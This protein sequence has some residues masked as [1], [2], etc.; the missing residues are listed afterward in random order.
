MFSFILKKITLLFLLFSFSSFASSIIENKGQVRQ[1]KL[2]SE[3]ILFYTSIN[4]GTAYFLKDRIAFVLSEQLEKT[5]FN[6]VFTGNK[7]NVFR[8]DLKINTSS[9]I[10]LEKGIA[11]KEK[12]NFYTDGNYFSVN[13]YDKI[14]YKNIA[15]GVSLVV[16]NHPDKGLKYDI[17]FDHPQKDKVNFSF[18]LIGANAKK[19]FDSEKNQEF[20]TIE[21]PLGKVKEEFPFI[22]ADITSNKKNSRI[23]K[24]CSV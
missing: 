4:G 19:E 9:E 17:V 12:T 8:Y 14:T 3:K 2:S 18:E 24:S 16:Y 1:E 7:I 5:N 6:N 11:Q 15:E 13:Q 20:I 10:I 21:T 22:Y 23:K